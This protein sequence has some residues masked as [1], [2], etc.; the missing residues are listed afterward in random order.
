MDTNVGFAYLA[1]VGE[2]G[3]GFLHTL[4]TRQIVII[5]KRGKTW[6]SLAVIWIQLP[7]VKALGNLLEDKAIQRPKRGAILDKVWRE[8]SGPN[9]FSLSAVWT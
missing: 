8:I 2:F 9:G 6:K 4:G 3:D 5:C 7:D 1:A